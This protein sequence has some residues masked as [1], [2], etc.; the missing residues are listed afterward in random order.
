MKTY[1]I[2]HDGLFRNLVVTVLSDPE[3]AKAHIDNIRA[4]DG[5]AASAEVDLSFP[6]PTIV[7]LYNTLAA[8]WNA[9]NSADL[10]AD[11]KKFETKGAAQKRTFA[12]IEALFGNKA[13]EAAAP[14]TVSTDAATTETTTEEDDM[15]T[16]G[17][18]KAK[19]VKVAKAPKAPRVKK[20]AKPKAGVDD[21]G[22]RKGS[23]NSQ[24]A[25]MFARAS[26]S[27]MAKVKEALGDTFYA[28][29]GKLEDAGHKVKKDGKTIFLT[30]K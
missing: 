17:K 3:E 19:K 21:F 7:S 12:L 11:V 26:G 22:L 18:K 13:P 25:A 30:A 8:I 14:P 24:A 29:L 20:E 2:T 9:Q 1:A 23:K 27:T 6:G 10:I 5:F 28:L 16:K 4:I 15:A